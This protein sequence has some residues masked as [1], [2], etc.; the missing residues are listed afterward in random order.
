MGRWKVCQLVA[1]EGL[2]AS[3]GAEWVGDASHGWNRQFKSYSTYLSIFAEKGVL[4]FPLL[5]ENSKML[6]YL[7][8]NSLI[9]HIVRSFFGQFI[10][11]LFF[12]FDDPGILFKLLR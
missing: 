6:H 3:K 9:E 7:G 4:L 1:W 5:L 8:F 12:K 10:T 11:L 2:Y